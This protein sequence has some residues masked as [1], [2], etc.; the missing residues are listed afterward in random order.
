V[1]SLSA[2]MEKMKFEGKQGYK[3]VPNT[4]NRGNFRRPNNNAPQIMPREQRDRDRNDQKIQTPLQ[5]NLVIDEEREE[6]ELDPEIH[7]IGDTSPFPHLTQSAYEESLMNSQINELSKGEKANSSPNKYNLWSKKKEGKSD[8][9]DQPS[10]A[11]KPAKDTT[12]NNKEK[13][14]QN[15]PPI[16]KDPVPE[17]RE[18]LKPP[19]S[20]S[21]EHEIQ[22][23]Q[24]PCA[25]FR[26]GQT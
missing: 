24:N 3:N 2:E 5:N 14:A 12:N 17:V 18:I 23:D 9:P 1:K 10:I 25:P 15:P 26:A 13:K 7:C 22:K 6:E 8:I 16:A 4:D 19:S 11:E 20:F 21:F